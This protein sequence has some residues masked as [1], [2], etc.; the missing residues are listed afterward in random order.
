MYIK[1]EK[2][3]GNFDYMIG[4]IRIAYAVARKRA[5]GPWFWIVV[6]QAKNETITKEAKDPAI[7]LRIVREY[8]GLSL[9][10]KEMALDAGINT[11]ELT[12]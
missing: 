4:R 9:T 11:K 7:A 2:T 3:R 12:E 1:I 5:Q 6:I 8:L 10:K